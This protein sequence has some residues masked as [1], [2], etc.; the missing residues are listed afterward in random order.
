[1]LGEASCSLFTRCADVFPFKSTS[2]YHIGAMEGAGFIKNG[3]LA[4]LSEQQLVDCSHSYGN[5]GC[6][7]GLM[8]YA[9][10]YAIKKGG[11]CQESDYTYH[12][13]G[14]LCHF[15]EIMRCEKQVAITGYKDVEAGS[16][17]ALMKALTLGPV[18]IAIEADQEGFQFYKSGVFDGQ[19]GTQL[20]HGVLLVGYGTE[21]GKD[22][23]LVKN[24]W[25]ADWG[26]SG[27]IKLVRGRNQC[28]LANSASYPTL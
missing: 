1:M 5:N 28:G 15:I 7:G 23:W 17:E 18:A 27:Y 26:S 11:I 6:S 24:S 20:D 13:K 12:A 4:S 21:D 10:E 22:Y 16:E 14:G 3:K 8:D 25:G 19:C 2:S 9:F